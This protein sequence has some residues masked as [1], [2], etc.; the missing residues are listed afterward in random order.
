ML[1]KVELIL[2]HGGDIAAIH[3]QEVLSSQL[4]ARN[5]FSTLLVGLYLHF[6][7]ER[8]AATHKAQVFVVGLAGLAKHLEALIKTAEVF[9]LDGTG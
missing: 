9:R 6:V 5:K 7:E 4:D 3:P 2:L 1:G 8:D